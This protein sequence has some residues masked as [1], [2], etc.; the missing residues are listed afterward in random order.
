MGYSHFGSPIF[1]NYCHNVRRT[2]KRYDKHQTH[3]SILIFV[4]VIHILCF[5]AALWRPSCLPSCCSHGFYLFMITP[6]CR[7]YLRTL[8]H[9]KKLYTFCSL[10]LLSSI[11]LP[12]YRHLGFRYIDCLKWF[13]SPGAYMKILYGS[14]QN[15]VSASILL[16]IILIF[17]LHK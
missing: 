3:W 17:D 15:H 16:K 13:A 1:D 4:K 5:F 7:A 2:R 6:L 9:N 14:C 11:C 10:S 12:K 8:N